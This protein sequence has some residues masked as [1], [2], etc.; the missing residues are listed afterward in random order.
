M[1]ATTFLQSRSVDC[2]VWFFGGR[3]NFSSFSLISAYSLYFF[4]K[5]FSSFSHEFNGLFLLRVL[6]G[7]EARVSLVGLTQLALF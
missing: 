4:Q 6:G 2:I 7:S 1:A 5:L 3:H